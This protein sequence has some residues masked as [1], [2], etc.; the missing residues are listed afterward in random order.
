MTSPVSMLPTSN[1]R[2]YTPLWWVTQ[3]AAKHSHRYES[4]AKPLRY[5]EDDQ[6]LSFATPQFI[7]H[8]GGL[9]REFA[10]N[11]CG[12]IVQAMT[13]R[14]KVQGIS[15]PASEDDRRTDRGRV[16]PYD[17][18]SWRMW[19]RNNLDSHS[20]VHHT[21]I[22]TTGYGYMTVWGDREDQAVITVEDPQQM[23]VAYWPGTPRVRAAALKRWVDEWTGY[24]FA[25]LYLAAS[26]HRFRSEHSAAGL[27]AV[28]GEI[29]WVPRGDGDTVNNPL[30]VVPV[31]EFLNDPTVRGEGRSELRSIIPIQDAINKLVCDMLLASE[32]AAYPQ[33]W[34][35]GL[36][37]ATDEKTGKTK[38]PFEA[39]FDRV[40]A[41]PNESGSFGQFQ[42]A[43]LS[44]YVKAKETL[45]QDGAFISRTPRHYFTQSGQSPSGDALKSSETGLVAKVKDREVPVGE[46]YEE[47]DRLGHL[48]EGRTTKAKAYDAEVKWA[49]PEY[50]TEGELTDA[51][52]KQYQTGLITRE[53]AL[54]RLG[55][56][57]QDIEAIG[58]Q[59]ASQILLNQ[60]SAMMAD[61]LND[62]PEQ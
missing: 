31:V 24:Q 41:N 53:Y 58:Q 61:L 17:K 18:D 3:L 50:R 56:S 44:N 29:S 12:V 57:P 32:F 62:E 38:K 30:G 26:V 13:E 1:Q 15:I 42:A 5:Y 4:L 6:N 55:Y 23:I 19:Q 14:M 16:T 48:V 39:A 43:D 25:T 37:P 46:G 27:T 8:F 54:E 40:W 33:R 34:A 51:V 28:T 36:E 9:F 47:V 10:V 22:A 45:I 49:D 59:I 35:I 11:I 52:I 7:E 21:M 2:P 20:Q 60:G